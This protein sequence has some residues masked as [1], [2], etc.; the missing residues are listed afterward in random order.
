MHSVGMAFLGYAGGKSARC[1]PVR[2]AELDL[3]LLV[4]YVYLLFSVLS[5]IVENFCK[6]LNFVIFLM[7]A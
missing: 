4:N 1:K 6:C 2:D 3:G 5:L 7:K